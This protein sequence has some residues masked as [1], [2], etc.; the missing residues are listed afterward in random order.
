MLGIP[1]VI[2]ERVLVFIA[3]NL[4]LESLLGALI[5][6]K[7]HFFQVVVEEARYALQTFSLTKDCRYT[8]QVTS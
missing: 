5:L 1:A 6:L 2:S 3:I 7:G 4:V 8:L